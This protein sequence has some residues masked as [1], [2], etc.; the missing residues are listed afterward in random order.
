MPFNSAGVYTPPAGAESAAPGDVIRSATWNSIFT[1]L[2]T[3]LTSLGLQLY[4]ATSVT[5]ATYNPLVTDAT[6][7][8]NRAGAVSVV[9]PLASARAGNPLLIK[10][11]SGAAST[12]PITITFTGGE[13]VEGLT[14]VVINNRYGSFKL[15]PLAAGNYYE[16]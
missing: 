12:N 1:D 7:L 13:S 15:Y 2:S 8:V 14:T 4:G 9:M 6:L 3:A 5:V 10:D 11:I 16:A